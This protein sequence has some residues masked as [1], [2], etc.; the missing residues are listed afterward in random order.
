MV[1]SS[2]RWFGR[3]LNRLGKPIQVVKVN[4]INLLEALTHWVFIPTSGRNTCGSL[5]M[6]VTWATVSSS[7]VRE[8]AN[9]CCQNITGA[10]HGGNLRTNWW[11]PMVKKAIKLNEV[12]QAWLLRY[13]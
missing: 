9:S 7:I 13:R 6:L 3:L 2:I 11:K 10:C 12:F 1:V 8:V 4:W 5:R